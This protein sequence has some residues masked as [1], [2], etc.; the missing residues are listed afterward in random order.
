[1]LMMLAMAELQQRNA[2]QRTAQPK[3]QRRTGQGWIRQ[4]NAEVTEENM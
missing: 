1:M 4:G 3:D 2:T